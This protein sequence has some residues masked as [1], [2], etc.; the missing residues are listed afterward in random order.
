MTDTPSTQTTAG[1]EPF[2]IC[3]GRNRYE[4]CPTCR[5]DWGMGLT[6]RKNG[7]FVWCPC[8]AEGPRITVDERPYHEVDRLAFAAWNAMPRIQPPITWTPA[9]RLKSMLEK[10]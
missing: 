1:A 4:P 8:G 6:D 3:D 2:D 10:G 5:R 7:R 9:M